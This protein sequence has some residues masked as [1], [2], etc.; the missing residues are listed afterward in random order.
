MNESRFLQLWQRN[1]SS[2]GAWSAVK[3][4]QHLCAL[5]AESFRYYH[6]DQHI[7][8]CLK[9]FDRYKNTVADTDSVELAIWFHDACYNDIEPVGHEGR[10]ATLFVEMSAG[11]M[12]S[13]RQDKIVQLIMDTM[14]QQ[15]PQ[16]EEGT[17]LVDV[18]LASFAR[19]WH[20]YLK[21]TARCRAERQQQTVLEFNRK[22]IGFLNS[23]LARPS[24]Y[25]T[26]V[27]IQHHEM[28][29]QENIKKLLLILE[30][31]PTVS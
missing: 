21:D 28:D 1:V 26:D 22:Q 24:V 2:E 17:L 9:W 31:R 10:S 12:L 4:Y 5:Y 11:G 19:P 15:A 16:S 27:F 13:E 30:Q 23:L 18:D 20:D 25:Y 6:N 7:I 14:H 8:E 3:V 29:A